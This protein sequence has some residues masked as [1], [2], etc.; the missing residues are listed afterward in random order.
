MARARINRTVYLDS[1]FTAAI[2][3]AIKNGTRADNAVYLADSNRADGVPTVGLA[4]DTNGDIYGYMN[5]DISGDVLNPVSVDA[6]GNV[7]YNAIGT[8]NLSGDQWFTKRDGTSGAATATVAADIGMGI[9]G[10]SG[11]AQNA[12]EGSVQVEATGNHK[13]IARNGNQVR[14]QFTPNG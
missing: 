1:S 11:G 5:R 4:T 6:D 7:T 13:V 8:V 12:P 10:M 3:A 2:I 9:S 14:V